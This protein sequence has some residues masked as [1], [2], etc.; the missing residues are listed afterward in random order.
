MHY[1]S[2]N[3]LTKIHVM[4]KFNSVF[5]KSGDIF[6]SVKNMIA[7]IVEMKIKEG[8][9]VGCVVLIFD[10]G[11]LPSC[12]KFEDV[13]YKAFVF[14]DLS[15]NDIETYTNIALKK[16]AWTYAYR[17][18]SSEIIN[19]PGTLEVGET[20]WPGCEIINDQI[21]STSGL[22]WEDDVMI[23]RVSISA[24]L[25]YLVKIGKKLR[26]KGIKFVDDETTKKLED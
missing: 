12:R 2:N 20:H 15:E 9:R 16:A 3:S 26:E 21:A 7:P 8:G 6:E 23:S 25:S 4:K 22:N 10:P 17:K 18:A 19:N 13:A 5:L 24:T 11:V 14:G 1:A